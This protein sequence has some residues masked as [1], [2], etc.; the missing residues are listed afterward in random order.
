MITE[1]RH[2]RRWLV[3]AAIAAAVAIVTL[4]TTILNTQSRPSV[5]LPH[6]FASLQW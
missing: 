3:L 4:N 5:R 2:P 1:P 6:D